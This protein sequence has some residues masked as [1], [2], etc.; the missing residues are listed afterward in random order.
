MATVLRFTRGDIERRNVELIGGFVSDHAKS[1]T[2][3]A[4]LSYLGFWS[5]KQVAPLMDALNKEW[6]IDLPKHRV[7]G[8]YMVSHLNDAVF[9]ALREKGMTIRED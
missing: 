2:P 1:V 5:P 9:H 3:S 4:H 8:I 7:S 6:E